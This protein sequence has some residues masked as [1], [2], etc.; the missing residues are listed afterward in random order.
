MREEVEKILNIPLSPSLPKDRLIWR[1][2]KNGEFFV[3][4]AYHLRLDIQA[5]MNPSGSTMTADNEVWKVCWNSNVLLVVKMFIWCA[6]HN[7]LPTR[8]N[9]CRR[10]VCEEA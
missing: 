8:M 6:C 1:C 4:S 2:T 7:L 10:G 5:G 3:K 9:L